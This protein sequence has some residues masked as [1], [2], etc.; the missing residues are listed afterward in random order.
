MILDDARESEQVVGE[1]VNGVMASKG[2]RGSFTFVILGWTR[3]F[4]LL[5][6]QSRFVE[7]YRKYDSGDASSFTAV[8]R[9]G[10]GGLERGLEYRL[11]RIGGVEREE[12]ALRPK[13]F[14]GVVCTFCFVSMC[15]F[16]PVLFRLIQV[17]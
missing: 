14:W 7:I 11:G 10:G 1:C 9:W 13:R 16:S 5:L 15:R 4:G 2:Q 12:I 6:C 8:A 3:A 17:C